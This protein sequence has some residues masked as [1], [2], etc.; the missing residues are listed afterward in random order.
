MRKRKPRKTSNKKVKSPKR[1]V[2]SLEN[3]PTILLNQLQVVSKL[4]SEE[5]LWRLNL[6]M[7]FNLEEIKMLLKIK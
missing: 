6:K 3:S 7:H 4:N 1:R 2:V 5:N